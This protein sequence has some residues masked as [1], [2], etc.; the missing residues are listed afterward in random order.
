[1]PICLSCLDRRRTLL[2]LGSATF[3]PLAG[4]Q[5]LG[6]AGASLVSPEQERAM[7]QQAFARIRKEMPRS[8]NAAYQATLRRVGQRIVAVSGSAIPPAQWDFVVFRS[9]QVN[10][11]ALPGGHV[12]AFE[13]LMRLVSGDAELAAVIGHEVGHVVARHSAQRVGASEVSQ[14]GVG[15]LAAV[16]GAYGYA[17]PRTAQALLGAGAEYGIILPFSRSQELEA[18]S[19]GLRLMAKAG[20][21]PEAAI[22]FWQKMMHTGGP[23]PPAILS[24]HP[25]DQERIARLEALLPEA[26]RTYRGVVG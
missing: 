24:T 4:C 9:D 11:F 3:A 18:D 2:L 15:V 5:Q 8:T 23:K 1:M 13:G 21:D 16:L 17:D 12:G 6:E 25:A 10:A 14:L 26:E 19:I 20:Y 22:S 7:G